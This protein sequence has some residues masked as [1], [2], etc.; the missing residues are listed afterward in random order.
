[1]IRS[2]GSNADT[3]GLMDALQLQK[4]CVVGLSMGGR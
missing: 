1:M 3:V 2:L 4:A